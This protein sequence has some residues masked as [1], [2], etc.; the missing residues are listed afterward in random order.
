MKLRINPEMI[1]F[2]IDFDELDR[3]QNMGEIQETTALPEGKLTYKVICLP[4][5]SPPAFQAEN[6]AYILSLSR[7]VIEN[8]K[9]DLPCLTGIITDFSNS[10]K[11]SLEVNLKKKI[12]RSQDLKIM[13]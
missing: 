5:G 4:A 9:A 11:V 1:C 6:G 12:K 7:D 10:V 8:H 2:R 13:T 3:L